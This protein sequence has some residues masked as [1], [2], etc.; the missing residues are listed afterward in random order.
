V[1]PGWSAL[2]TR[3]GM[4]SMLAAI[5]GGVKLTKVT[6]AMIEEE[7]AAKPVAAPTGI[8]AAMA[9]ALDKR[10]EQ[11][12]SDSDDDSSDDEGV[13]SASDGGESD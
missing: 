12:N 8:M 6:A 4:G 3:S 9:S 7:K 1:K 2:P 10:R 11:I 5:Q 13:W